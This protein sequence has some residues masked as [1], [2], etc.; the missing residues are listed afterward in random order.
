M[1]P[2]RVLCLITLLLAACDGVG[3]AVVGDR[4]L[5]PDPPMNACFAVRCDEVLEARPAV[6]R[7][8]GPIGAAL[9]SC[10]ERTRL[11]AEVASFALDPDALGSLRCVDLRLVAD[12]PFTIDL[13]EVPI[14]GARIDVTS[15]APGTLLLG[16]AVTTIDL[17]V[18]G[19][20]DVRVLG[21]AVGESHVLLDGTAPDRLA[22]L[23]TDAVL[24]TGVVVEAPYGLVRAHQSHLARVA[25]VAHEVELELS[26]VADG[27]ITADRVALLD[28]VLAQVDLAADVIVGAAGDLSDVDIT[29]CGEVTLAVVDVIRTHVARCTEALVLDDADL[30][31]SLLDADVV[32][33]GRIRHSGLR[34]AR[35]ELESSRITLTALCGVESLSVWTTSVE[36]PSC[37][38]EAP[39]EICGAPAMTQRYCP[40]YETAPCAGQPRPV[41]ASILGP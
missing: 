39:A 16:G 10:P 29:R 13:R 32:G 33:S 12:A 23:T 41:G 4:P 37:E 25:L 15:S 36:C 26:S 8:D 18:H 3:V 17:A 6:W 35:V 38:P 2:A 5:E 20:I 30:E 19:P 9:A 24:L 7:P 40:G 22:S 14:E 28:A 11:E 21:G 31:R 34:G 27:S 1:T